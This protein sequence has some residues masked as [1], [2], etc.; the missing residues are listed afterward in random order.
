MRCTPESKYLGMPCSYVGTGC[1][2]EDITGK[3][4][5]PELPEDLRD[6]GYLTLEGENK[7][8]RQF[9]KVKKKIYF[10][11]TERMPLREFLYANTEKCCVCVYGHFIYVD[12]KNYWSFF[13]NENDPVV[14][15]WILKE[16]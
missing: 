10:R 4:F 3:P 11:R 2:Y 9:L 16:E 5:S 7:F 14:C 12:G 1:A 13:E 8:L 6:D 15:V